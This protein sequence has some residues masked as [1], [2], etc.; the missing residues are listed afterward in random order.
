MI[1]SA[2]AYGLLTFTTPRSFS[3]L[4]ALPATGNGDPSEGQRERRLRHSGR[5]SLAG[6]DDG[7]QVVHDVSARRIV[8]MHVS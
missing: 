8:D 6:D 4:T 3:H 5:Q 7:I 1:K 2:S